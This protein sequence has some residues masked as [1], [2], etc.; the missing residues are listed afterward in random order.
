MRIKDTA[1]GQYVI[2]ASP[3]DQGYRAVTE[4]PL[5]TD[6]SQA[7]PL[8]AS[9]WHRGE[10]SQVSR[11]L[12]K[13]GF[14]I[15]QP[16]HS[17]AQLL[18]TVGCSSSLLCSSRPE[19]GHIFIAEKAEDSRIGSGSIGPPKRQAALRSCAVQSMVASC[20][21]KALGRDPSNCRQFCPTDDFFAVC[22]KLMNGQ[23]DQGCQSDAGFSDQINGSSICSS[24]CASAVLD[25]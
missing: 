23:L 2:M 5:N 13:Q 1:F 21:I 6:N 19:K 9:S 10:L 24:T 16:P 20:W 22:N 17:L 8:T 7:P 12:L 4:G 11:Q 3:M 14:A 15:I 18:H 25:Q